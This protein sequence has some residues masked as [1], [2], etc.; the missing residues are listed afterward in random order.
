LWSPLYLQSSRLF[1]SLTSPW[2]NI[3]CGQIFQCALHFISK[4]DMGT[5]TRGRE[6]FSRCSQRE[7]ARWGYVQRETGRGVCCVHEYSCLVY[8]YL[9]VKW[10][11]LLPY[12]PHPVWFTFL[13]S[14]L[15]FSGLFFFFLWFFFFFHI[16]HVQH[17]VCAIFPLM[18]F[19][20]LFKFVYH[21]TRVG[22]K[23]GGKCG[24]SNER[25]VWKIFCLCSHFIWTWVCLFANLK[26]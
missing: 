12:V 2:A 4:R 23:S 15:L 24:E 8:A 21:C 7:Q 1:G 9:R 11:R 25:A 19:G 5:R 18:L 10:S 6:S 17:D 3:F 26:C 14:L 13:C 16:Q 22:S 20:L